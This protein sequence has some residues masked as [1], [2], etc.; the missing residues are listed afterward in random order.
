MPGPI[1]IYHNWRHSDLRL[2]SIA[3]SYPDFAGMPH[4]DGRSLCFTGAQPAAASGQPREH[5]QVNN[6]ST[7]GQ[8]LISKSHGTGIP[9]GHGNADWDGA[10]WSPESDALQRGGHVS[11]CNT[12][13]LVFKILTNSSLVATLTRWCNCP[14]KP[15]TALHIAL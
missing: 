9:A 11:P 1:C 8:I 6:Q 13:K 15:R 10:E 7:A 4:S 2:N 3:L 5:R 12:P 14:A